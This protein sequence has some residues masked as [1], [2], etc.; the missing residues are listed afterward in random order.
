MKA[1]VEGVTHLCGALMRGS[2]SELSVYETHYILTNH[3]EYWHSW[4]FQPYI[5]DWR[6][7]FCAIDEVGP[8]QHPFFLLL[9]S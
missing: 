3:C 9:P 8:Y 1:S 6:I 2:P 5:L 7:L 4:L